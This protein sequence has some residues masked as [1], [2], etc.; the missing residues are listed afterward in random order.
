M[1]TVT[2]NILRTFLNRLTNLSGNNRSLLLL[3]LLSGQMLDLY[4][5]NVL[6]EQ[7]PFG[8]I[9]ALM[10]GK[11][12][13]L[14]HVVDSRFE[15]NNELSKKIKRLQ[16]VD[17]FIFEEQGS[18]DLHIG[19]PFVRGKF[20]DGTLV[21]APLLFFPVSIVQYNNTWM[22][23]PREDA[24]ISFNKSFLLAY[25]FYNKIPLADELLDHNFDDFSSDSTVFRTELYQLIKE[26]IEINFNPDNFRDELTKFE[27]FKKDKY[28]AQLGNGEIKLFPEAVLGIFPQAGSQLVPDYLHLINAENFADLEEFFMRHTKT[29]GP[30]A[31]KGADSN[32]GNW[33]LKEEKL[34]TPFTI[35]AWQ[36]NA[37]RAV[38]TGKSIVV[39]GPP[40]TG[41]SQ[42]ICNLM[43]DAIA[44]G[45]RVL[46]V[47]QKRAALDVVYKRLKET[48]L[49]N[50]LGLV[51]DFRNDRRGIFD[52]ICRQIEKIDDYKARNRSIDIIQT[53]RRFYQLSRRIDQICEELEEFRQ[54]LY[55]EREC[56]ISI[57]ELYLTSNLNRDTINVKQEFQYF[58]FRQIDDFLRKLKR[59]V[60]YAE[61][62]EREEYVWCM[63]KPFTDLKATDMKNMLKT[64][65]DIPACQNA[66]ADKIEKLIPTR[67]NLEHC[68][69]FFAREDDVLG[70]IAVL[71][72][73][74][75]YRFF[76]FMIKEKDSETSLLWLSNVERVLLNCYQEE[77]PEKTLTSEQ[78]GKF[79]VVLHQ[80]MN[81]RRNLIRLLRWELFSKHKNWIKQVLDTNDLHYN[82][83]GL[84]TLERK[85]DNRLNLEHHA[86]ALRSKE[87]LISL[88][89]SYEKEEW[90]A[91][92][93]RTKMA[94]RAKLIFNSLR[95]VKDAINPE[96][97]SHA[98]FKQLFYDLLKLVKEVPDTK[99][100]WAKDLTVYQIRQ[101]VV[102]PSLEDEFV[103]TLKKDFDNLCEYDKLKDGLL[104]YERDVI[105]KLYDHMKRWD[106]DLLEQLLQNSLRL[107]WIEYLEAKYPL[108]RLVSTLRIDELQSE[109]Q[110][111]L[112]EK[113][114]LSKEIVL[115]RARE[116]VS[117]DIEYN[118][119][120]NRITYRD[121]HH[122]VAKKKKIW[123]L[124]R[125]I[126]EFTE[127]VFRLIPCW[128]ASPESVSAIFPMGELFDLVVFDEAS[129]CFAER[130]IPAMYRGA[131]VLIA[132]DSQQLKPYELYQ[133]RWDDESENPDLEVDSL[134]NLSERYLTTVHLQGHYRSHS[135][136]LIDFSN[137]HFY[138]GRLKLLPDKQV[139]NN[140][141]PAI[142]YHKVEGCWEAKMNKPEAEA[143][144]ETVFRLL[145]KQPTKEIGIITF[146]APQ[147]M[148]IMDLLEETSA[149]L[150]IPLPPTLFVKNI[151]NVQ[152]DE[153][154]VII[155]SIGYAPDKKGKLTM[156]FG[157]LNVQGGEN[158]LNVAITRAR[159]KIIIISS[160]WPDQ[161][162]TADT[163]NQGPRLL[164]RYL[165]FANSV[166]NKEF[167]PNLL[168]PAQQAS[169]W[170]LKTKLK[171]LGEARLPGV[172]FEADVLPFSDICFSTENGYLG[173]ILTDDER[174]LSGLS[175]KDVH[176][177][178]Q[179][180]LMQK[181]WDYKLIFSRNFWLDRERIENE[182]LLLVGSQKGYL[183]S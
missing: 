147:Q 32:I 124:R 3:R 164:K 8:I 19:W 156:Q 119:L 14:C 112:R 153:R 175:V 52:K 160:I 111:A 46:L 43:A 150:G 157:S 180:L 174:Y 121:L 115:M 130:G 40:G 38:K 72:D 179:E 65:K 56:G 123:P 24:G 126:S 7:K 2:K 20:S 29:S 92:F 13:S 139:L 103:K 101:L 44:S 1:T 21:R 152:G 84:R 117:E 78:L 135:L 85:L 37:I 162:S 136:E 183:T 30:T 104:K 5:F 36:E 169:K 23:Q 148:L 25:S 151:E 96:K 158:R 54:T 182:L 61:Q 17:K 134:L 100:A 73:E 67:L 91:W 90:K 50:F 113:Q 97:F 76:Q 22:V 80:R 161:L 170:Y 171:E 98:E 63:R 58:N 16:R 11:G 27:E 114:R 45:K 51:H 129:Q 83:K 82:R 62:F 87:W 159:K 140:H 86:T 59:Y 106:Y 93:G 15:T 12:K 70:M 132:G 109:L 99:A 176:A 173:V 6:N 57:K 35:D 178:T 34:Y 107:A 143:V 49:G 102:E 116:N 41:K 167:A 131:Q 163:K 145:K 149:T 68:Q 165:E 141:R 55:D 66:V 95:E 10:A 79:Q 137:R 88:P 110:H 105:I 181:G 33:A 64:V 77:G 69:S 120:N 31:D 177:Y 127:E 48:D 9:E 128:M 28:D 168:Q 53:E 18:N 125:V 146:N 39:Q 94:I 166:H 60:R 74:E 133:L 4:Q 138:E 108:L 144:I 154:D 75:T 42:L 142:E 47:C 172:K 118:R 71:K 155:F 122:Q 89:E 81:A 26:K